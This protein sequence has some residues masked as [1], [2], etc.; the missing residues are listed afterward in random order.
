MVRRTP[1]TSKATLVLFAHSTRKARPKLDDDDDDHDDS[2]SHCQHCAI[3]PRQTERNTGRN[4]RTMTNRGSRHRRR[5]AHLPSFIPRGA[6]AA[7]AGRW[8]HRDMHLQ[9]GK[10]GA[11]G[12]PMAD[13]VSCRACHSSSRPPPHLRRHP[14]PMPLGA[15]EQGT[16][17]DDAD[18][19]S[20]EMVRTLSRGLIRS[21]TR[22]PG[23]PKERAIGSAVQFQSEET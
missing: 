2:S 16:S 6:A 4:T 10:C 20:E 14:R 15:R 22:P 13:A 17:K 11:E 12:H 18:E 21:N 7:S 5:D 3:H 1:C 8:R 9:S 19:D 23:P